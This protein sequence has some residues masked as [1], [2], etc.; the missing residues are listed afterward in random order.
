MPKSWCCGLVVLGWA[1]FAGMCGSVVHADEAN[2]KEDAPWLDSER[3]FTA[4]ITRAQGGPVGLS[5]PPLYTFRLDV[6][7]ETS[8]RGGDQAGTALT[9]LFFSEH[10]EEPRAFPIGE[11]QLVGVTKS[12]EGLRVN[13]IAAVDPHTLKRLTLAASYPYGWKFVKGAWQSPWAALDAAKWLPPANDTVRVCAATNRPA[14]GF[15]AAAEYKVEVVPSA[16]PKEW[17]NPDG[18]GEYRITVT[19]PTDAPLLVPALLTDG[20]TIRWHE[21]LVV[22]CQRKTYACPGFDPKAADLSSVTLKPKESVSTVVNL[23]RLEGPE[24]PQGGYRIEFEVCLGDRLSNQSFYYMTK[25][26]EP[27]RKQ[28]LKKGT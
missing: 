7:V 19:N 5:Q 22:R 12:R 23:L 16:T 27:L 21:S 28:L 26:H 2:P 18:D 15:P 9:N 20:K 10:S 25:H 1:M 13:K 14:F 11:V 4:K 17:T 24:W 6:V 3:L 8:L